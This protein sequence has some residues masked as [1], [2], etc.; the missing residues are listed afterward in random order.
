MTSRALPW[1]LLLGFLWSCPAMGNDLPPCPSVDQSSF[2]LAQRQSE[3]VAS[4]DR[5]SIRL[6]PGYTF[7]KTTQGGRTVTVIAATNTAEVPG[8]VTCGCFDGEGSCKL[9]VTPGLAFCSS[10]ECACQIGLSAVPPPPGLP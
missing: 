9:V 7:R 6:K 8:T 10:T 3:G 5:N 1:L 4:S 2:Q